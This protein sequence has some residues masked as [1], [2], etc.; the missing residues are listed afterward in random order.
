MKKIIAS[1]LL[2][3]AAALPGAVQARTLSLTT[4]LQNYGGEGA[5]LAFYVTDASGDRQSAL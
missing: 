4:E 3:S 5:Y 2:V 1:F